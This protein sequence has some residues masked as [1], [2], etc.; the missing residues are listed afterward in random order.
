MAEARKDSRVWILDS[1]FYPSG[2][3][4]NRMLRKSVLTALMGVA[5]VCGAAAGGV[6]G[7]EAP[8]LLGWAYV[9]APGVK[10]ERKRK[11]TRQPLLT[12]GRGAVLP[13]FRIAG[14]KGARWFQ[15]LGVDL[16]EQSPVRGWVAEENTKLWP[17][18]AMPLAEALLV[19]FGRPFLEDRIAQTTHVARYVWS[20]EGAGRN[21]IAVAA[22]PRLPSPVA[23]IFKKQG[24]GWALALPQFPSPNFSDDGG[25]GLRFLEVRDL[26]GDGRECVITQEPFRRIP[27]IEGVRLVV[28]RL[29]NG[30][31]RSVWE[32][33][34]EVSNC[35]SFPA[36]VQ[37]KR[38][39]ALNIG[40]PGTAVN[41]E[42][43]FVEIPQGGMLLEWEGE[44]EFYLVGREAPVETVRLKKVFRWDGES[45][46]ETE[47]REASP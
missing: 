23:K 6:Q 12:L 19:H 20:S 28:R 9:K 47:K 26:A 14:K 25:I 24:S 41:G 36:E 35:G 29:G 46:T 27:G 30:G 8:D 44:I 16:E 17:V 2:K 3:G 42:I 15:V 45:F 31:L 40:A 43:T 32:V 11:P 18:E 21:L 39:L 37:I 34:R 1:V 33:P 5:W 38:P 13:V 22:S 10:I 4:I 7:K